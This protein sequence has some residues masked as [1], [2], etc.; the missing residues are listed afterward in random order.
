[1]NQ[2]IFQDHM[3][4]NVCFG[5]GTNNPEGLHIKSYWQGDKSVCKWLPEEKYHG[6]ANLLNGGILATLIDCHCMGTAMAYAYKVEKRE[7]NSQPEYRYATGTLTVKYLKPTSNNHLVELSTTV[8]EMKGRKTIMHC[9]VYSQGV[10]T[11]EAEVIAIRVFD[12]NQANTQNPF[13]E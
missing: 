12:G 5:C 7:L 1:M 11:A 6:W 3:P 10:K 9:E 2:P 8:I 13:V 4:G